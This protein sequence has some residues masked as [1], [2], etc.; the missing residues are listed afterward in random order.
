MTAD[1]IAS[2]NVAFDQ[3][4][5]GRARVLRDEG[6]RHRRCLSGAGAGRRPDRIVISDLP[7]LSPYYRYAAEQGSQDAEPLRG[8]QTDESSLLFPDPITYKTEEPA[9][10]NRK[11]IAEQEAETAGAARG[12]FFFPVR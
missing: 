2:K 3:P 12:R 1:Q 10:K 11:R 6:R 9:A 8:K 4:Y 7:T 5:R